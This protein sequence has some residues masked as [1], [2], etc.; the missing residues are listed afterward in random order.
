MLSGSGEIP[1]AVRVF[2]SYV[3]VLAKKCNFIVSIS[4]NKGILV[5]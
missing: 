4:E 3:P 5:E 1:G 2:G